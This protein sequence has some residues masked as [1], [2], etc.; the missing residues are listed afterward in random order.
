MSKATI[1]KKLLDVKEKALAKMEIL[2]DQ[3]VS[4]LTYKEPLQCDFVFKTRVCGTAWI[5]YDDESHFPW[6]ST[7]SLSLPDAGANIVNEELCK[8]RFAKRKKI[9]VLRI[10][11]TT[12]LDEISNVINEF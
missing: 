11:F 12:P 3:K 4:G 2:V 9:H 6:L 7:A 5:L 10:A 8:N 1:H